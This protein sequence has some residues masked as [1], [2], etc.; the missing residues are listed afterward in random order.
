MNSSDVVALLAIILGP[1]GIAVVLLTLRQKYKNKENGD[2]AEITVDE[3]RAIETVTGPHT[4][5][6]DARWE[7]YAEQ[8]EGRFQARM[9]KAD[10][11]QEKL[12]RH[13]AS[14]HRQQQILVRRDLAWLAYASQLRMDINELRPPPPRDYPDDLIPTIIELL[15]ATDDGPRFESEP[16]GDSKPTE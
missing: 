11:R 13:I 2:K 15:D 9:N 16:P 5:G 6:V 7:A 8:L 12:E 10:Q 3:A 1:G 4:T 14:Q